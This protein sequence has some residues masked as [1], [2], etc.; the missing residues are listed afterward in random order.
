MNRSKKSQ[1]LGPGSSACTFPKQPPSH[2]FPPD[3]MP[4]HSSTKLKRRQPLLAAPMPESSNEPLP[5][6]HHRRNPVANSSP[7]ARS[8][9]SSL[10]SRVAAVTY[11]TLCFPTFR[12]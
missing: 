9:T 12:L 7:P 2:V 10:Q 11:V 6:R 8:L 3:P 4:V 1:G 5:E